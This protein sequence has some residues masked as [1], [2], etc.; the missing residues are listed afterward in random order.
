MNEKE[1]LTAK[2]VQELLGISHQTRITWGKSGYLK[3]FTIGGKK[4]YYKLKDIEK[5]MVPIE[6]NNNY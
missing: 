4:V 5:A 6:T 1:I 2:E 3:P